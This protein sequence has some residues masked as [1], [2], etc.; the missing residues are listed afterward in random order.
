ML[1]TIPALLAAALHVGFFV[2]ESVLLGKPE[3]QKRLKV[4]PEERDAVRMW[5]LNQGFYN[6]MLAA[7]V[8]AGV[9]ARMNG[10]PELGAG[11]LYG[12]CST[13]V[14]AGVVLFLSAPHMR[15]PALMQALPPALALGAMFA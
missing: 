9:V 7:A 4:K 14:G 13:M 3:F 11:L 8:V 10:Q 2:L 5:A 6:L 1:V 15:G 12:A